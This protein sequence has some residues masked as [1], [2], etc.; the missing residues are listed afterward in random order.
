MDDICKLWTMSL[1][2]IIHTACFNVKSPSILP[3]QYKATYVFR[4]VITINSVNVKS[5][6]IRNHASRVWDL[7]MLLRDGIQRTEYH[8]PR[9]DNWKTGV[10]L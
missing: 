3:T 8:F 4:V 9:S 10:T 6:L 1:Y 5:V 7:G 2:C